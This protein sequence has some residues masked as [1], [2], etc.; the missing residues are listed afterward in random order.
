MDRQKQ[1]AAIQDP[2]LSHIKLPEKLQLAEEVIH[3]YSKQRLERNQIGKIETCF[4]YDY[5]QKCGAPNSKSTQ[6]MKTRLS[7]RKF[8]KLKDFVRKLEDESAGGGAP[9][10][11][12]RE[13]RPVVGS[14][15]AHR[16]FEC[17]TD[18]R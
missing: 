2:N 4:N 6:E 17:P 13:T 8:S 16:R 11:T 3:I 15:P 9:I 7:K 18:R 12:R 10:D 5:V 14:I 1:R